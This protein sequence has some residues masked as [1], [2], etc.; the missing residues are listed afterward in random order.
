MKIKENTARVCLI[1]TDK[2]F[3]PNNNKAKLTVLHLG[4]IYIAISDKTYVSLLLNVTIQTMH[5]F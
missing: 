2:D 5:T 1:K 4:T 3:K